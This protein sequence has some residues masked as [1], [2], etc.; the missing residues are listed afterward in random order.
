MALVRVAVPT[1]AYAVKCALQN[2]DHPRGRGVT[3]HVVRLPGKGSPARTF[4]DTDWEGAIR[5]AADH[6]TASILP[7][8]RLCNSPWSGWRGHRMPSDLLH[9]YESGAEFEKAHRYDEALDRYY[10]ALEEDPMNIALRLQIGFLQEKLALFVDA[11]ATYDGILKVAPERHRAPARRDRDRVLLVARYRRAVLL[12]G[13]ELPQQWRQ[14]PNPSL[15]TRRDV[16]RQELREKLRPRLTE[17]VEAARHSSTVRARIPTCLRPARHPRT[18]HGGGARLTPSEVTLSGRSGSCV[19]LLALAA[20]SELARLRGEL[21]KAHLRPRDGSLSP[22]AV[23]LSSV[24]ID[25]HLRVVRADLCDGDPWKPEL[26]AL[27]QSV[28]RVEGR[29]FRRWQEHYNAACVYSMPLLLDEPHRPDDGEAESLAA[30]AVEHLVESTEYADSG[31]LANRREWVLSDDPDLDGLRAE[32]SFKCFETDFFPSAEPTERRPREAHKW[33]LSRYTLDLLSATAERWEETWLRRGRELERDVSLTELAGWCEVELKAWRHVHKVAVHHRHWETRAKL[34][35]QMHRWQP[36]HDFAP[37]EVS[38]PCFADASDWAADDELPIDMTALVA[39]ND[40]CL[41][42]VASVLGHA[43][44]EDCCNP[45]GAELRRSRRALA[46]VDGPRR[47]VAHLDVAAV[48]ESHG[49]LWNTLEHCLADPG[50][51]ADEPAVQGS[52]EGRGDLAKGCPLL[53]RGPRAA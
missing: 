32:Q 46:R 42:D 31:Y 25:Q 36:D 48:C 5:H 11:L 47:T 29:G 21:R 40:R 37:L 17:L 4:W 2:R 22:A 14:L 26:A 50:E 19:E 52:E 44:G 24:W 13:K 51:R 38:F 1:H 10:A 23:E 27:E 9:A 28:A 35:K 16:Q 15:L 41:A 49:S 8:T 6:A 45:L 34:I 39:D 20:L 43:K 12:G 18:R 30:R 33:E 3:V 53:G 7:R